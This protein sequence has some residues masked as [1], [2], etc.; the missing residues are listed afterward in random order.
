MKS[1]QFSVCSF[2]RRDDELKTEN[3]KLKT[4]ESKERRIR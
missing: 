2:Q 3:R 4:D 1:L